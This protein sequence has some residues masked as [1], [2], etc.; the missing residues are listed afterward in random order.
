MGSYIGNSPSTQVVL[1]MLEAGRKSGKVC[2]LWGPP[3]VG[4]TALVRALAQRLGKTL[5]IL[6]PSTMDPTD[7]AGLPAIK[8]IEIQNPDGEREIITTT[9]NTATWWVEKAMREKDI[10]IFFDEASTATPAVQAALLSVLQGRTIGRYVIPD[11]V[12][13]IAAA[14]EA[15]DAADG[16]ELAPPMA[17]RFIHIDYKPDF[18]D[19][20]AGFAQAWGKDD[21]T[22]EERDIR[23]RIVAFLK[24][25][26]SLINAMPK[27]AATAGKAW[28]SF[29]SWDNLAEMVHALGPIEAGDDI[30]LAAKKQTFRGAV[31]EGAEN[32]YATWEQRLRLTP[33]ETVLADPDA[34]RGTWEGWKSMDAASVYIT[35]ENAS[36]SVTK[37]NAQAVAKVFIAAFEKS[38]HRDVAT[39]F[40]YRIAGI[41]RGTDPKAVLDVIRVYRDYITEVDSS[42]QN[43]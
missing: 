35:L 10:I 33:L 31:G 27:D 29:R 16:W 39:A 5:V 19:F 41:F 28:P 15:E 18:D 17:N 11:T 20:F 30:G 38:N 4:K 7:I 14:N 6:I 12:W 36:H 21:L 43:Y 26:R 13:M 37:E 24:D 40:A 23:L 25:N 32:Q 42:G 9:E 22:Q 8:Q 3:G 2:L 34:S 1:R